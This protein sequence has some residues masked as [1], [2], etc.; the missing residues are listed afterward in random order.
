MF[1]ND[2]RSTSFLNART[3]NKLMKSLKS[4]KNFNETKKNKP[5][6]GY[7]VLASVLLSEWK[8]FVCHHH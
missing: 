6:R 8:V 2:L 3:F 1:R 4:W 5:T 7:N